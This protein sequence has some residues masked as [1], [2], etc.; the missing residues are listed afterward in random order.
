[1]YA[2]QGHSRATLSVPIESSYSTSLLINER[3]LTYILSRIV[4]MLLRISGQILI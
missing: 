2:V 3:Q 4:S 1:M